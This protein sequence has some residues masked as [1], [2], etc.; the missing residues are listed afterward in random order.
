MILGVHHPALAVPDIEAALRFYCEVLGFEIVMDAEIPSGIA[1]LND[2]FGVED[3]GCKVRMFR[4]GNSCIELFEFN[5]SADGQINR[6]VNQAG[7]THICLATDDYTAAIPLA[8]FSNSSSTPLKGPPRCAS[9][10]ERRVS[11]GRARS[12]ACVAI[13]PMQSGQI[14]TLG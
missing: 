7:I 5:S 12:V 6:P 14:S 10:P 2:A 9:T 4:K 13:D 8:T 3:A 1:P 11:S